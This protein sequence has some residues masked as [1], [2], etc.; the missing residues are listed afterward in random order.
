M[1]QGYEAPYEVMEGVHVYRHP[2]PFE[3]HGAAGYLREYGSALWHEVRLA[4]QVWRERGFDVIHACNPPDL[5]FLIA[6]MFRPFGVRF[7]FDHHD[8]CPE[9]FV[10]K[11][12]RRGPLWLVT[13]ILERLTFMAA[14]VSLATNDSFAA[15]AKRRGGMAE[16]DV[17]VVRSAP[18][19]ARF[20]P[21]APDPALREGAE[22]V[23]GYVGVIGQ[24]EGMDLLVEAAEELVVR[25]GRRGLRFVIIGFGTQLEFMIE[26]VRRRG[27]AEHF[28]FTG[29]LYGEAMISALNAADICVSPD[30]KNAMNDISTMNKVVEYMLLSKP[31]V[32]FDLKEGRASA[33]DAS[34]YARPNDPIHFAEQIARLID[35]PALRARLGEIGRERVVNQLSWDHSAPHLLAAYDRVFS[36]I[37]PRALPGRLSGALEHPRAAE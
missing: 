11:F 29:A 12:G 9:L 34:L 31:I 33:Q 15:I 30:P 20:G 13:R 10:A 2:Q 32:Q 17:F 25:R 1:G 26:D 3:A 35:D 28:R 21:V 19:P 36:R 24:Q 23:I 22:T 8:V 4:W 7:V 6:L 5:I 18:R 16:E 27:L 37:A 14:S